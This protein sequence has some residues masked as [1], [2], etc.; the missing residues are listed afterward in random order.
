MKTKNAFLV[1]REIA[2][3]EE[4]GLQKIVKKR[5][6]ELKAKKEEL[7]INFQDVP[8]SLSEQ[9]DIEIR[10]FYKE[11]VPKEEV[12]PKSVIDT[13]EKRSKEIEKSTKSL[14]DKFYDT[15]DSNL[16]ENE[17]KAITVFAEIAAIVS[18]NNGHF[19]D[20]LGE[21]KKE[22]KALEK[23]YRS[24][25]KENK[26]IYNSLLEE[27]TEIYK[28]KT[29]I[30]ALEKKI[31]GKEDESSL[32]DKSI[33]NSIKTIFS[34]HN[35]KLKSFS[36]DYVLL[37]DI[38]AE[39]SAMKKNNIV[40]DE[41]YAELEKKREMLLKKFEDSDVFKEEATEVT[42]EGGITQNDIDKRD[43]H[44]KKKFEEI[45]E[46]YLKDK[47]EDNLENDLIPFKN[48]LERNK[49]IYFKF[50]DLFFNIYKEIYNKEGINQQKEYYE[51]IHSKKDPGPEPTLSQSQLED[52]SNKVKKELETILAYINKNKM[53]KYE[54]SSEYL[55]RQFIENLDKLNILEYEYVYLKNEELYLKVRKILNL[56]NHEVDQEKESKQLKE[57]NRR[58][59][60]FIKP[61]PSNNN[62]EALH[63]K[64][65]A[66]NLKDDDGNVIDHT[67]LNAVLAP[68]I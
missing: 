58:K 30:I 40:D 55:S 64:I 3:I 8:F 24:L 21:L 17:K 4:L 68:F 22:T 11:L 7:K 39:L 23:I 1:D 53:Y 28:N 26:E 9:I 48:L 42:E 50:K 63:K 25:S 6:E 62:I 31:E 61:L 35:E 36:E 49:Y 14:I 67:D 45:L 34:K 65:K 2:V 15:R 38:E 66:L 41:R 47:N 37:L 44:I 56:F 54:N 12:D 43:A 33:V 20:R 57:G 27:F 52:K 16:S 46:K 19:Q 29:E 59:I 60:E 5:Y 51:K 13:L 10:K 32:K 18:L